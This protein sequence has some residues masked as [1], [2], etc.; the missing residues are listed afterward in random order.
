M[1]YQRSSDVLTRPSTR[2]CLEPDEF[3][4]LPF[5]NLMEQFTEERRVTQ[6][7]R[8]FVVCYGLQK[9]SIF[10][11]P[12]NLTM[13]SRHLKSVNALMLILRSRTLEE[14]SRYFEPLTDTVFIRTLTPWSRIKYKLIV[15]QLAFILRPLRN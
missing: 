7:F 3:S 2:P 5:A 14:L 6:F 4:L 9:C 10:T 1:H 11:R 13:P 15:A 8:T 12:P